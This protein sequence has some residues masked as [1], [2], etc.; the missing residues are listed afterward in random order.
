MKSHLL[1]SISIVLVSVQFARAQSV[2]SVDLGLSVKWATCNLGATQAEDPGDRFGWGDTMTKSDYSWATLTITKKTKYNKVDN[3]THLELSDDAANQKM[4]DKWRMPTKEEYEEL[5]A[6]CKYKITTRNGVEG[7]LMTSK[8][9]GKSVFFPMVKCAGYNAAYWSSSLNADLVDEAW[10]FSQGDEFWPPEIKKNLR[11]YGYVIRPVY[12]PKAD[13]AGS[14]STT[15]TQQSR[16]SGNMVVGDSPKEMVAVWVSDIGG[17]IF[18]LYKDETADVQLGEYID[19]R[20]T[21]TIE[22][23]NYFIGGTGQ[24]RAYRITPN[25]ELYDLSRATG[26]WKRT[27]GVSYSRAK[28]LTQTTGITMHKQ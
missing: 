17:F 15:S 23:G 1:L 21:W 4:G 8:K 14:G 10:C 20:T 9:N 24:T 3:K 28:G 6:N 7:T 22:Q 13:S 27:T 5:I 11:Y 19:Y 26:Q 2:S 25:G 12:D 18:K 16:P